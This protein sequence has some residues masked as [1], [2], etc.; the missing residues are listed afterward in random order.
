M[1]KRCLILLCLCC[2][3]SALTFGQD[4]YPLYRSFHFPGKTFTEP[5]WTGNDE[6][7]CFPSQMITKEW[8]GLDL[9]LVAQ[10][11]FDKTMQ[12][13]GFTVQTTQPIPESNK[14][15]LF[16]YDDL[17]RIVQIQEKVISNSMP[18]TEQILWTNQYFY[19]GNTNLFDSLHFLITGT[20]VTVLAGCP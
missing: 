7:V 12:P 13:N 6:S 15:Q 5:L 16:V 18:P 14:V 4:V 8:Q 20:L 9:N 19:R 17:H 3:A 11:L 10:Q 1:K 2:T